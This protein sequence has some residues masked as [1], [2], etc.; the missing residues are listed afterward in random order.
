MRRLI[1][2]IDDTHV[3]ETFLLR[4]IDAVNAQA[5]T[6]GFIVDRTDRRAD[7]TTV[8]RIGTT[9]WKGLARDQKLIATKLAKANLSLDSLLMVAD[10][11]PSLRE[12]IEK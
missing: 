7:D 9:E 12:E 8:L 4:T 1:V 2:E 6:R 5:E 11:L 3:A 10:L